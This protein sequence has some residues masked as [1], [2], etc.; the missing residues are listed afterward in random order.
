MSPFIIA[1]VVAL[2][3]GVFPMPYGYYM[4]SRTIV[5]ICAIYYAYQ[6]NENSK[7]G[8]IWLFGSIALLYNPL[9]PIHL[10]EKSLWLIVNI[11]TALVFLLQLK[12]PQN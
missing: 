6:S 11:I 5:F 2:A 7:S 10:G 1:P 12:K 9:I 3:I 4:L 8:Y